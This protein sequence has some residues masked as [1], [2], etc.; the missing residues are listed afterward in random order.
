[1]REFRGL[2][3]LAWIT[4]RRQLFARKTGIAVVLIVMAALATLV[5]ARRGM[6]RIDDDDVNVPVGVTRFV[7]MIIM[8]IYISFL[9]PVLSLIYAA[10]AIGEERDERTLVYLLIRPLSRYRIYLAKGMGILPLV[11]AVGVGGFLLICA[12][13]GPAGW[14]TGRLFDGAVMRGCI[15]YTALFLLFGAVFH[16]PLVLAV[17][18]AFFCETLVGN[19]PGTIKRL[20]VSFHTKC[21]MYDVGRPF[22]VTPDSDAQFV[23]ISGDT[24]A[25]VLDLVALFLFALGAYL[26]HRKEYRDFAA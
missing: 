11:L 17:C 12:A 18:Y 1:V 15:V 14:E 4:F 8:P 22:G 5:W 26:F 6:P 19:M 10:S 9:L 21:L 13:A 20:A 2:S 25:W 24:A 3:Y 23:A 7:R 16:R